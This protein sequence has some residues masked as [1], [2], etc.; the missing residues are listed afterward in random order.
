[1]HTVAAALTRRSFDLPADIP[2]PKFHLFQ[3]VRYEGQV[4]TIT[5]MEYLDA[6][7]A[8]RCKLEYDYYDEEPLAWQPGWDYIM[9]LV[10]GAPLETIP[11]EMHSALK[12]VV[13]EDDL[14]PVEGEP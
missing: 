3:R 12:I 5:G 14:E 2:V 1:M 8:L 7:T 13:A 9:S 11:D 6:A 4:H 10:H